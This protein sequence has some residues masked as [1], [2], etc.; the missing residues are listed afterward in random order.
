MSKRIAYVLTLG[1]LLP[2]LAACGV[3]TDDQFGVNVNVVTVTTI[4]SPLIA[5]APTPFTITGANFS[6]AAGTD[7]TVRFTATAGTPFAGGTSATAEV[8]GT[9]V[10]NNTVTGTSPIA[11]TPMGTF[12]ATVTVILPTTVEGTSATDIATFIG[13]TVTSMTPNSVQSDIPVPFTLTGD[14]FGPNGSMCTITFTDVA[15]GTPFLGGT[16]AT[17]SVMG[18]VDSPTQI[19]AGATPIAG[20][21]GDVSASVTVTLMDGSV[22]ASAGAIVTILAPRATSVAPTFVDEAVPTAVTI[23]GTGFA[24]NAGAATVT[25]EAP[26]GTPFSGGTIASISVPGTIVNA[27]TVTCTSPIGGNLNKVTANIRVTQPSGASGVSTTPLLTFEVAPNAVDDPSYTAIGNVELVVP[28][29][30]G[31]LVNDSDPD[32]DTIS[33]AAFDALSVNGGTVSV[34]ADG[35]FTYNPA[36]GYEGT[37]TFTYTITDGFLFDTATVTVTVSDVVWFIDENATVAGDGRFTSPFDT[38]AAFN[39]GA[40]DEAGDYIFLYGSAT[41]YAGNLTLLADQQLIGQGVALIVQTQ[42]LVPAGTTPTLAATSGNAVT[43]ATN[44][45]VRGL[46][47]TNTS[48][49]GIFGTNVGSPTIDTVSLDTTGDNAL[50]I[51]TAT[52][53]SLTFSSIT[54]TNS[55]AD[56]ILLTNSGG[57]LEVTGA[58]T[59]TNPTDNGLE[60]LNLTSVDLDFATISIT[61][62]GDNGLRIQNVS[63]TLDVSG[64]TTVTTPGSDGMDLRDSSATVTFADLDVTNADVHGIELVSNTGSFTLDEGLIDN[65]DD[66]GI[67]ATTCTGDITLGTATTSVV[68]QETGDA[69]VANQVGH[70]VLFDDCTGSLR[71]ENC[72]FDD[73]NENDVGLGTD[74]NGIQVE[75]DDGGLCPSIQIIDC[76]FVGTPGGAPLIGTTT[77]HGIRIALDNGSDV[78]DIDI[79]GCLCNGLG[80]SFVQVLQDPDDDGETCNITDLNISDNGTLLSPLESQSD[81]VEVRCNGTSV[82]TL[83]HIDNNVMADSGIGLSSG[84]GVRINT[85]ENLTGTTSTASATG[86]I[87]GNDIDNLGDGGNDNGIELQVQESTTQVVQIDNNTVDGQADRGMRVRVFDDGTGDVTITNNSVGTT[88][89]NGLGIEVQTRSAIT[90]LTLCLDMRLNDVGLETYILLHDAGTFSILNVGAGAGG[91]YT[92]AQV[93]TFIELNNTGTSAAGGTTGSF[94]ECTTIQTP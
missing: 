61:T 4:T 89:A 81:V 40:A 65:P 87:N 77:D 7:A 14:G 23:T 25:F 94:T 8:P 3:S 57:S 51:Q 64:N 85:G 43:L 50:N 84:N 70:G 83:F 75:M 12:T 56:A 10:D 6:N 21:V 79:T 13:I 69:A 37:D 18:T 78:T 36:P 45:T 22:G 52:A 86:T 93:D 33:V 68:V 27:T 76:T 67:V 9:I 73:I 74:N 26:S 49:T 88:L 32:M 55:S 39:A 46:D 92:P 20:A 44:N 41:D 48:G 15:G 11:A 72:T 2:A 29:G 42:T 35:S 28:V 90:A 34:A 16:S 58:V 54:C 17:V 82:L 1:I 62:P 19:S 60:L 47:I 53:P 66:H 5:A 31:V 63:G 91:T 30:T 80:R 71:V 38:L 59:L 24:P